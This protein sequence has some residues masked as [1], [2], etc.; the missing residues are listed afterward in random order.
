MIQS[1]NKLAYVSQ[2]FLFQEHNLGVAQPLR[3]IQQ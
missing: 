1:C 3:T 2:T